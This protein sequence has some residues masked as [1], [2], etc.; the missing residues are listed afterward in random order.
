MYANCYRYLIESYDS[1]SRLLPQQAHARAKVREWIQASEGTFMINA[2][3]VS[4]FFRMLNSIL[5]LALHRS[6]TTR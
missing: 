6:E 1:E 4:F 5:T 2:V 3:P